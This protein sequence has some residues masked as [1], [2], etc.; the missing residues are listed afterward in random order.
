ML[1]R[2]ENVGV[3]VMDDLERG[4]ISCG[5]GSSATHGR[6]VLEMKELLMCLL[7]YIHLC[8]GGSIR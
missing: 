4:L 8:G 3:D 1:G 5:N 7:L 6:L 2:F